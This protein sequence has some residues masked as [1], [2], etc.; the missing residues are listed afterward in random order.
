MFFQFLDHYYYYYYYYYYYS[1][2][3][4]PSLIPPFWFPNILRYET[5]YPPETISINTIISKELRL[6]VV[7]YK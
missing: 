4:L 2:T 3:F 5:S 6:N 7:M 1:L